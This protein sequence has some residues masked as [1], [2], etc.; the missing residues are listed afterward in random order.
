MIHAA[1]DYTNQQLEQLADSGVVSRERK[2]ADR[3]RH[4]DHA[5]ELMS[6]VRQELW[7]ID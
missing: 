7:D 5:R 6:D 4:L 2:L 1:L 3:Y